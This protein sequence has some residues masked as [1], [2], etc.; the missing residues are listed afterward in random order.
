MYTPVLTVSDALILQF[1]PYCFLNPSGAQP[2]KEILERCLIRPGFF[3]DSCGYQNYRLTESYINE[4]GTKQCIEILGGRITNTKDFFVMCPID[5]CKYY[6]KQNIQFAFT[7]DYPLIELTEHEYESCLSKSYDSSEVMF[8]LRKYLCPN[9]KLLI[10]L[11]CYTKQQLNTYY[12]RMSPLSPDGYAIPARG[13]K[14]WF[15]FVSIA[16]ILCFLHDHGVLHVHL[17]GSSRPEIIALGAAAVGLNLFERISFDS[18]TWY[19]PQHSKIIEYFDPE[20]FKKVPFGKLEDPSLILPIQLK[21]AL[22][23]DKRELS[24]PFQKKLVLL[25]N[26]CLT[27]EYAK[28]LETL[29]RNFDCLRRYVENSNHFKSNRDR[30]LFGIDMLQLAK[31]HGYGSV[32]NGFDWIWY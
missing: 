4:E 31:N 11:H 19:T 5:L 25:H 29:G 12:K 26:I 10:P 18:T 2:K 15:D 28:Y 13:R 16:Y 32:E 6:G 8:K 21:E 23:K 27:I 7:F 1:Y 14:R 20:T 22:Q 17:F 30:V 24:Q 9:T 3:S